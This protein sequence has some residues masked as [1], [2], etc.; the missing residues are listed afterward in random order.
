MADHGREQYSYGDGFDVIGAFE[1]LLV[2]NGVVL[3]KG[4]NIDLTLCNVLEFMVNYED[5]IRLESDPAKKASLEIAFGGLCDI[6]MKSLVASN[7]ASWPRLLPH[8]KKFAYSKFNVYDNNNGHGLEFQ[9]G[10]KMFEYYMGC[11]CTQFASDVKIDHPD[12]STGDNPDVIFEYNGAKV[13]LACKTMHSSTPRTIRDNIDKAVDQIR[14]SEC[15]WGIPV[16]ST[17]NLLTS[18]S[19]WRKY[20]DSLDYMPIAADLV[21]IIR[22]WCDKAASEMGS[23]EDIEETFRGTKSIPGAIFVSNMIVRLGD[24]PFTDPVSSRLNTMYF[25]QFISGR[26]TPAQRSALDSINHYLQVV[27]V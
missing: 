26:C 16:I 2:K 18:E 15:D 13:G 22:G 25:H 1:S 21:N 14:E 11:I 9:N 7:T 19:Y 12:R 27:H 17:R 6:A 10:D 20:A 8:L 4:S 24:T 23:A 5:K 3:A